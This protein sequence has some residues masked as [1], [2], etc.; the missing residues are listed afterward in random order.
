M[1]IKVTKE[2]YKDLMEEFEKPFP[3]ME[4]TQV[5]P[6]FQYLIDNDILQTLCGAYART[7]EFM[8]ANGDA[9]SKQS[10]SNSNTVH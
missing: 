7:A 2:N 9:H 3:M 4:N 10:N 5:I 1:T 6:L 8:I